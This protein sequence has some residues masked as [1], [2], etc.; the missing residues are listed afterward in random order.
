MLNFKMII[1][2]IKIRSKTIFIILQII[3]W[4]IFVGLAIDGTGLLVKTIATLTL[5]PEDAAK[6]WRAI[7]L[8]NVYQ[9][10][11]TQYVTLSSII[12]IVIFLKVILFYCIIRISLNKNFNITTPFNKTFRNFILTLAYLS[13]GIGFF[14][15]WG[16]KVVRGLSSY[17]LKLQ[18]NEELHIDGAGVWLFMTVILF[19]IAHIFKKGITLQEESELTI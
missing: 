5:Q 19:V 6:F 3:L 12:I 17:G 1:M 9:F 10:N 15:S 8:T 4:I 2:E 13:F 14:S 16:I 7:D 11:E 18:D